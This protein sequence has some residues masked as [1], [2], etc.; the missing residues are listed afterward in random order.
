MVATALPAGVREDVKI[1]NKSYRIVPG[2][3]QIM[4]VSDYAPRGETPGTSASFGDLQLYQ[5]LT[6]ESWGHGVGYLWGTDPLGYL[7]TEGDIDAR[8]PGVIM[9]SS[10][11]NVSDADNNAAYGGFVF[12]NK[13]Y[14]WGE[15]G[16]RRLDT[17]A[18]DTWATTW[19]GGINFAFSNGTYI[20][21]CPPTNLR[22]GLMFKSTTG[23]VETGA[24]AALTTAIGGA[25]NDLLLTS[26]EN[27][28]GG[29]SITLTYTDGGTGF[30]P[31]TAI[32]AV[33]GTVITVTIDTGVTTAAEVLAALLLSS[34]AM[35]LVSAA[36]APA[37][38]GT[39]TVTAGGPWSLIGGTGAAVWTKCGVNGF[40]RN[41]GR[42]VMHNGYT[43]VHEHGTNYIH[44]GSETDLSDLEGDGPIDADVII[45]GPGSVPVVYLITFGT[46]LYA[47]RYD[48][49]WSI[50]EDNIARKVLD[51]S[52]EY[53]ASNFCSMAV[54]NGLLVYPIQ[55]KIITWNGARIV[56]ITPMSNADPNPTSRLSFQDWV[57]LDRPVMMAPM[58]GTTFEELGQFEN[59]LSKGEFL[60]CTAL[61]TS[62]AT[63]GYL[64]SWNGAG[65]HTINSLPTTSVG[66]TMLVND[67]INN[68][69]WI[70]NDIR[71]TGVT[72][73]TLYKKQRARSE[74]P[75]ADF[76]TSGTHRIT[77][78]QMTMGQKRVL[79]SS[80]SII[81]SAV[82]LA[83]GQ[84]IVV[85]YK[86]DY[87]SW[88][89]LGTI[90]TPGVTELP[91]SGDPPSVEYNFI[92]LRFT[93]S[94]ALATNTP[95]IEDVTIRY[96]M[97]PKTVY[98]WMFDVF[99]ATYLRHGDY[100]MDQTS[101]DIR[102]QLKAARD[103]APSV[104]YKDLDGADYYCYLTSFRGHVVEVSDRDGLEAG[105]IE[106]RF[107]VSLVQTGQ[108][109]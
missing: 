100:I 109:T 71:G 8:F 97:R 62:S 5:P 105:A 82:N 42:A 89:N 95:I 72:N 4:D 36:N 26:L 81:V 34:D 96:I 18:T 52:D 56:D 75:A 59:F 1:N 40:A 37:N 24:I 88:V 28:T 63:E 70:H 57:G 19:P 99:G 67:T 69:F 85:D 108:I 45:V 106:Y 84:T 30:G 35:Y 61:K 55:D 60:Y 41:F 74:Y 51:Y 44:R 10:Q 87:G 94:C 25:N 47:A 15:V 79:K 54:W 77:M 2:S 50:G 20:F 23:N 93:L 16:L 104:K 66:W 32:V 48:G 73:A 90:S 7:F 11:L 46:A 98:G 27:G 12:A 13:F 38:N 78:S 39:G 17:P 103:S 92:S 22:N 3:Y 91:F 68:R 58:D 14:K 64:L 107:R 31:G 102:D 49:L 29:N 6:Q 21:V 9:R 80:P 53:N 43:Y 65:W 101:K 83:T 33:V 76:A 86:L